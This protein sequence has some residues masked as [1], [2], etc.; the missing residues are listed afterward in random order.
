MRPWQQP[1]V[2]YISVGAVTSGIPHQLR[3][4]YSICRSCRYVAAYQYRVY[5]EKIEII[6]F[7]PK[8]KQNQIQINT[9]TIICLF[10]V[11]LFVCLLDGALRHFRQYF[12][13][14]EAVS[15]IDGENRSNQRKSP[16]CRKSLTNFSTHLALIEIRTK[17]L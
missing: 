5:N 6:I 9:T 12:G 15:F 4:V 3:H 2:N 7:V 11:C 13:Y 14:I 8:V 16:T 17:K 10:F 1:S